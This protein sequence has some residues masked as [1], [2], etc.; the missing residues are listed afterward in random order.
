N[1][2]FED[3]I[4]FDSSVNNARL[5]S[6]E[7]ADLDFAEKAGA[8]AG[9]E[10]L[11]DALVHVN[12]MRSNLGALDTRLHHSLA[13]MLVYEE[14]MSAAKMRIRDT[15]FA[16]ASSEMVRAQILHQSAISTMAQ[17]NQLSGLALKLI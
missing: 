16:H 14:N 13:N 9:L 6:L 5:E 12:E 2:D 17:S 4:T 8:Q 15:D 7:L 10:V 11:D 1:D 3:R